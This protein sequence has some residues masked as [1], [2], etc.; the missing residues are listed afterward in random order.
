MYVAVKD[1]CEDLQPVHAEKGI[2][3]SGDHKK[4]RVATPAGGVGLLTLLPPSDALV[5]TRVTSDAMPRRLGRRMRWLERAGT[6]APRLLTGL[7]TAQC[8]Q[9]GCGH[10]SENEGVPSLQPAVRR[11]NL[12]DGWKKDR[13]YS[14]AM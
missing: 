13:V 4:H 6:R 2:M 14:R 12:P 3:R 11:R 8:A 1:R 9:L 10:R 5:P 7:E